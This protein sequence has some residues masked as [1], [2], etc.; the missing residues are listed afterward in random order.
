MLTFQIFKQPLPK[1]ERPSAV[2]DAKRDLLR[3]APELKDLP[4]W[5][6]DDVVLFME[7]AEPLPEDD[8][9]G[10]ADLWRQR[11]ARASRTVRFARG[12]V[13]DDSSRDDITHVLDQG[14]ARLWR[15]VFSQ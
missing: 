4:G 10:S 11:L 9:E 2:A 7:I 14:D 13:T 15:E 8:P 3:H 6:F 5:M 12:E 1:S